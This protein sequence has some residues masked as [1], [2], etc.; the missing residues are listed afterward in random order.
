MCQCIKLVGKRH[1]LLV[2]LWRDCLR[3]AC[4]GMLP[5]PRPFSRLREK[6][7]ALP[8]HKT[9]RQKTTA[10]LVQRASELCGSCACV[11]RSEPPSVIFQSR[12]VILMQIP[13]I[14]RSA[15]LA[16]L[17]HCRVAAYSALKAPPVLLQKRPVILLH[18][19]QK[20]TKRFAA[21]TSPQAASR[22][23]NRSRPLPS[24]GLHRFRQIAN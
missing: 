3:A 23:V 13:L 12:P 15:W 19:K 11:F 22:P 6:G 2:K 8:V 5:H 1:T 7:A 17:I 10:L 4:L 14:V 24:Y 18:D 9:G 21:G 20:I 16:F